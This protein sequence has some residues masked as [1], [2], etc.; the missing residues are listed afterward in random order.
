[1]V[2]PPMS[3]MP[4]MMLPMVTMLTMHP[5][6]PFSRISIIGTGLVAG[7]GNGRSGRPLGPNCDRVEEEP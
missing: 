2:M 6:M 1:M 3:V 5:A 7:V 4:V